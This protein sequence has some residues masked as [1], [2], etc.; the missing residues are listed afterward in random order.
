M[1]SKIIIKNVE[2]EYNGQRIDK[3][4]S[5][6]LPEYSRSFIQKVV[7]DGGVLVDEKCV[8]SN[9]KLSAGQILKL[10]V[11]ELVEPDIIPEDIALDI[12]YE[13]D[14]IIVVNKPKGMVVH[15][16]A[17]HYTGTLVNALMYHCR[18]N[19]SGINGVTRPGIV[20]RIDM[21]TT[22]VLV[23]CKNDAAHIFLSEQ[24]AV[25]SITRKYNAI[26]HNSFKD[27]SGTVDAPIG[28]HHI[29]RKKMAID[30][31]N[32]RNAVTHYSVISNY[33]KYAHIEC[34]LETGRTHQIRVH[35]SSIGHPLLGDDVY[36]SGKSPYRLEG[37]T[38]HARVLG[39]VH[40]STR[41]YMEFEAPL[42]DYFKEIIVDLDNKCK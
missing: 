28:R 30:Y 17:G 33:G 31:K 35:M 8:K 4:L 26:V 40:P 34:Q 32:G 16:A 22:G 18:D 41:K 3:F 7:K 11:P 15:P 38:L 2:P 39:F 23:A 37:Q 24:L 42:P 27:N 12:L 14:D 13:D 5:E 29:D 10:N 1:S 21:N 25:H 19:L 20:H 36:G 6:T 9:Y